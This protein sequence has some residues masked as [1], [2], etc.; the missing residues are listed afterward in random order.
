MFEKRNRCIYP[1]PTV[2]YPVYV[3]LCVVPIPAFVIVE[4]VAIAQQ[5]N[6]I[7]EETP[8]LA[9]ANIQNATLSFRVE[10]LPD[11]LNHVLN[12][13][14][15]KTQVLSDVELFVI[16]YRTEGYVQVEKMKP[17][18]ETLI[19]KRRILQKAFLPKRWYSVLD[20]RYRMVKRY[21]AE[22]PDIPD[23]VA[24]IG[25][26]DNYSLYD[27]LQNEPVIS[28]KLFSMK[29]SQ[30]FFGKVALIYNYIAEILETLYELLLMERQ[31]NRLHHSIQQ[32]ARNYG[33]SA[34]L[35]SLQLQRSLQMRL[36]E[37]DNSRAIMKQIVW[38]YYNFYN[39]LREFPPNNY[40]EFLTF[41]Q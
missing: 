27:F 7:E 26:H 37:F 6:A 35:K 5:N 1:I 30:S 21:L 24:N 22:T 31:L 25:K 4:P 8:V 41:I 40:S 20:M 3:K 34:A 19:Q 11:A 36:K 12:N 17:V 18:V 28:L 13:T 23:I 9:M 29:N 10:P 16:H 33:L 2:E 32:C 14:C 38:N 39:D 15:Y